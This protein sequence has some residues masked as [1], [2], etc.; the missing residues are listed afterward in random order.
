[1]GFGS[2]VLEFPPIRLTRSVF[3]ALPFVWTSPVAGQLVCHEGFEEYAPDSRVERGSSSSEGTALEG[4]KGWAGPYNVSNAIKTLV[5]IENR[6]ANPV[7]YVQGEIALTG[8]DRALRFYDIA[9]GTYAVRRPLGPIFE[10]AAGDSLWFSFL[11]R[12]NNASPLA[13]QDFFQVGFDDNEDAVSGNPRVSI[14]AATTSASFP[15]G[16]QFF[17]RSSTDVAASFFDE[18]MPIVAATTYLLVGRIEPIDGS[19]DSVSLYV[20]PSTL[21]DP[22]PPSA[23]VNLASGLT[24]LTHAFIRTH[25]LDA[26]DAYVVD[27]WHIGRSYGAVVGSLRNA[28]QIISAD[29]AGS[30]PTLRWSAALPGVVLETSTTLE[31]GSWREVTEPFHFTGSDWEFPIP[32]PPGASHGFYRLRR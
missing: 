11:F 17:A 8:G 24:H 21:D 5:L 6:S 31:P 16:F 2:V 3:L 15:A 20:N 22:G 29:P 30:P 23:T 7:N 18:S 28:L 25:A 27:E 19:Y 26:G 12:T 32:I 14:G 10:A 1:M 9:N 13:N 4:G